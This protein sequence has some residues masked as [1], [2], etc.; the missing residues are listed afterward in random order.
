MPAPRFTICV[1]VIIEVGLNILRN[2][3][4]LLTL[5]VL[6]I[7]CSMFTVTVTVTSFNKNSS[8][9]EI[10]NVNFYAVRPRSYPNSLK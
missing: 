6:K 9:D 4:T 8:G 3:V 10:A 5:F 2:P 1:L 7:D